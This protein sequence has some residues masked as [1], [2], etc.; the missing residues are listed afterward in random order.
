L[1]DKS[2]GAQ[3]LFHFVRG[4]GRWNE[5]RVPLGERH[6]RVIDALDIDPDRRVP[7]EIALVGDLLHVGCDD[8]VVTLRAQPSVP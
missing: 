1:I 4:V 2:M 6:V 8:G 5:L 7:G 3:R